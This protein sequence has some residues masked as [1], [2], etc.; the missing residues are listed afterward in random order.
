MGSVDRWKTVGREPTELTYQYTDVKEGSSNWRKTLNKDIG[1]IYPNFL[2]Y[3]FYRQLTNF[4]QAHLGDNNGNP[5]MPN[6][7]N[8]AIQSLNKNK[9]NIQHHV[10]SNFGDFPNGTFC[11][12]K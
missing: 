6:L 5:K 2:P 4:A 1:K 7:P 9:L 10:P 11:D 8:L 3:T 12:T